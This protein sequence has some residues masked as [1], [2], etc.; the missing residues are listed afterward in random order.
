MWIA[1]PAQ[2]DVAIGLIGTSH[3]ITPN[4]NWSRLKRDGGTAYSA[5]VFD[6]RLSW[7]LDPRQRRR[8]TLQGSHIER[9]LALY[10]PDA[11]S[12]GGRE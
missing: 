4:F 9:D 11:V 10:E 7:Q 2:P 8:L 12:K 1:R 5:L 6:T 3:N